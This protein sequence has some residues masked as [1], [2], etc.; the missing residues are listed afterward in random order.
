MSIRVMKSIQRNGIPEG[1]YIS[2]ANVINMS[3]LRDLLCRRNINPRHSHA[4]LQR[5]QP[6]G[7]F[8]YP[9]PVL[10]WNIPVFPF[11]SNHWFLVELHRVIEFL[12]GT[13]EIRPI[14]PF[15]NRAI[16]QFNN[17]KFLCLPQLHA[18]G[19]LALAFLGK[20]V[21]WTSSLVI[22]NK[23]PHKYHLFTHNNAGGI[24]RL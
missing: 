19:V 4:G 7:F 23:T 2:K 12:Q 13:H 5:Y 8:I 3:S 17:E 10:F 14:Y 11:R 20:V 21:V 1:W 18:S 6:S 9:N 22:N 24:S 16:K 15:N